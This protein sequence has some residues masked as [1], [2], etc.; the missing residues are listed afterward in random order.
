M[1]AANGKKPPAKGAARA[2]SYIR[3]SRPEQSLGDSER[4][5]VD[6]ARAYAARK[7]LDFD[8]TLQLVD[9]GRSGYK[10][11][12]RTKGVLGKFLKAVEA[13]D[14]PAGSIL[15]VENLDRLSRE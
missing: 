10:G 14:V 9:R 7:G 1:S 13:G 15:I 2:Y 8:E 11:D 4:R 5:Q 3:F 6:A 12:H